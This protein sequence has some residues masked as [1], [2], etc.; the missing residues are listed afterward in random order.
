MIDLGYKET[1][2]IHRMVFV[3]SGKAAYVEIPM[4]DMAALIGRNNVGKTSGLSALKLFVLPEVNFKNC[5]TKFRF[6]SGGEMFSTQQSYS[7]YFPDNSS[8]IILEAENPKNRFC[9]VLHRSNE[10][11]G[12]GRVAIAKP[13]DEIKS[14]FWDFESKA[15][16]GYGC[17][18]EDL[19]LPDVIAALKKMGGDRL[20]TVQ[21]IRQA[22]YRRPEL[23][24]NLS[25]Y[26]LIPMVQKGEGGS[27]G[28]LSALLGLAFDIKGTADRSLPL[29]I[30]TIIEGDISS[31]DSK[32]DINV[33][34]ISS[35]Y[36]ALRERGQYLNVVASSVE[37]W[38]ELNKYYSECVSADQTITR[39]HSSLSSRLSAQ[40]TAM[41][42]ALD[43]LSEELSTAHDA[44]RSSKDFVR[45][46][47]NTCV[48][49]SAQLREKKTDLDSARADLDRLAAVFAE[50]KLVGCTTEPAIKEWLD[51]HINEQT[52]VLRALEDRE[53]GIAT[54][55]SLNSQIR[56]LKSRIE[57]DEMRHS[58][59]VVSVL[60]SLPVEARD[61]LYSLNPAL[62]SV[63]GTFSEEQ[64]KVVESFSAL[65]GTRDEVLTLLDQPVGATH[66]QRYDREAERKRLA[67][68]I[69]NARS[70]YKSLCK[71]RDSLHKMLQSTSV[72]DVQAK[73]AEILSE[74]E[75]AKKDLQ[76]LSAKGLREAQ[77]AELATRVAELDDALEESQAELEGLK[78]KHTE[79]R[80]RLVGIKQKSD[81][82]K[83]VYE[84]LEDMSKCVRF[85]VARINRPDLTLE[86][87]ESPTEDLSVDELKALTDEFLDAA[88][89]YPTYLGRVR[90]KLGIMYDR[91]ILSCADNP[92]HQIELSV[93]EISQMHDQLRAEFAHLSANRQK[94]RN[95]IT[96]HNHTTSMNASLLKELGSSIRSAVKQINQELAQFRISNLDA[97]TLSLQLDPRFESLLSQLETFG[98]QRDDELRSQEFYDRL[99]AFC[100][101]FF[102]GGGVGQR[103]DLTSIINGVDYTFKIDGEETIAKQS[104]GTT[105]MLNT[106]LL[107]ILLKRLIPAGVAVKFPI[108]FDEVGSLDEVNL[109]AI[110]QVVHDHGFILFVINPSNNGS[111]GSVI[112]T[113]YDLSMLSVS[114]GKIVK[115][116]RV[117]HYNMKEHIS[118]LTA[119]PALD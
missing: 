15:N 31:S 61:K 117:L 43:E 6:A 29:A 66:H 67:D 74:V 109:R 86:H 49:L 91:D 48:S 14:L 104:N 100:D 26:C 5:A 79:C 32:I 1:Y 16:E 64:A 108:V 114:E 42:S 45:D 92:L 7:H 23:I 12:Y 60:E 35:E 4:A 28:A 118:D 81:N 20:S 37:D 52:E 88:A 44:E 76:L 36:Q 75:Q 96:A 72:N 47:S 38:D 93:G 8:F 106:A 111:L 19:S 107:S 116:C 2:T 112:S 11:W 57:S 46:K 62:A 55:E 85:E 103:L 119:V 94:L 102:K 95:D 98:R 68:A 9:M 41:K 24:D 69:E 110:K 56:D 73:K 115:R 105:S 84:D 34:G 3:N 13:F 87:D 22:I 78:A 10:E 50:A 65:L 30:A 39:L 51:S 89:N 71:R 80:A 17:P 27:V 54:L 58:Q 90:T 82:Q 40:T 99:A 77:K 113:W 83:L 63:S 59:Q 21:E 25:R 18:R 53:Q 33:G 70:E 101:D 97:V